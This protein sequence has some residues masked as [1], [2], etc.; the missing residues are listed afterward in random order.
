MAR[1]DA[2]EVGIGGGAGAGGSSSNDLFAATSFLW[3][4]NAAYVEQLYERFQADPSSVDPEWQAF[5]ARLNDDPAAVRQSAAGP[6]WKQHSWPVVRNGE[7][8]SALD[9][10]W[11]DTPA[12]KVARRDNGSAPVENARPDSSSEAIAQATRDSVRALMMIRA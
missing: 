5:F 3:G 7:L 9:G 6:S 12:P 1:Q 8:V 11:P 10:D 4:G 2:S